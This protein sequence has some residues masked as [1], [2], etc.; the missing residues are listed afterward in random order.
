MSL[1]A[2]SWRQPD[3]SLRN[4][5]GGYQSRIWGDNLGF[6]QVAPAPGRGGGRRGTVTLLPPPCRALPFLRGD[7]TARGREVAATLLLWRLRAA[8][9]GSAAGAGRGRASRRRGCRAAGR[10]C[11]LPQP[12]AS[13]LRYWPRLTR[14]CRL[15]AS[16]FGCSSFFF[17]GRRVCR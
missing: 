3:L 6:G 16:G 11:R 10:L 17:L 9:P 5:A 14:A 8:G 2:Q 12:P 4:H 7:A 1:R 15:S 13:C